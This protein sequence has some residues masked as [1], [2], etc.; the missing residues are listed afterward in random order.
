MRV[1]ALATALVA[2]VAL[3]ALP[4]QARSQ[5]KGEIQVKAPAAADDSRLIADL[6]RHM[7]KISTDF[8]GDDILLFG[9]IE[10]DGDVIV[11]VRGPKKH[12]TV[13]RKDRVAGIWMNSDEVTFQHAPTFYA[14][15]SAKPLTDLLPVE[16]LKAYE[17]GIPHL[18]LVPL[19]D[20][21]ANADIISFRDALI[22]ARSREGLFS[23]RHDALKIMGRALFRADLHFPSAVP[24]GTYQVHVYMVQNREVINITSTPLTVGKV[25]VEAGI[26]DLAQRHAPAYGAMA[27]VIAA[28]AGWLASVVFRKA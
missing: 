5:A 2:F 12:E 4:D 26:Y 7:V 9:A 3:L 6:S 13:R 8:A 20:S 10:G 17:I 24:V 15:V 18:N 1:S 19:G 27:I 21:A 16:T 22:R 25:G 23:E 14:V 11:V 28:I